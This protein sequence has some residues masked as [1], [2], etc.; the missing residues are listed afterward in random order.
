[1]IP[2]STDMKS[3]KTSES[4]VDKTAIAVALLTIII[5]VALATYI[6][7]AYYP[8]IIDNLFKEEKSI[9][10][11]DLVEVHYIGR[12]ASNDSIFDSSI[13]L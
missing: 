7:A 2:F 11:G 6:A 8:D 1:M 3:E 5:V 4:K 12:Y 10:F 9:E 13:A